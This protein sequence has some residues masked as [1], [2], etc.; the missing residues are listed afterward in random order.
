MPF[1]F[2]SAIFG[3]CFALIWAFIGCM[4]VRDGQ[5]AVR[6]EHG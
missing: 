5:L 3:I 4:I 2:L 1:P 6:R